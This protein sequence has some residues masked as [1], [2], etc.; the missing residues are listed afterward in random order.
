MNQISPN[1]NKKGSLSS[2]SNTDS[3]TQVNPKN[4]TKN[5][6]KKK[7][8][9]KETAQRF[10]NNTTQTETL[11]YVAKQK[12]S[13]FGDPFFRDPN[14][15][16]FDSEQSLI[17]V[18]LV[19]LRGK[20]IKC[21]GNVFL[22][23][24]I[25]HIWT[26]IETDILIWLERYLDAQGFR[27]GKPLKHFSNKKKPKKSPPLF[28]RTG[29]Q[30]KRLARNI[31]EHY[32]LFTDDNLVDK[33]KKNC[34]GLVNFKNGTYSLTTGKW[35]GPTRV[36][37]YYFCTTNYNFP[38]ESD[39]LTKEKIAVLTEFLLKF[40]GEKN[41]PHSMSFL[42]RTLAGHGVKDRKICFVYGPRSGAK[43]TTFSL[44]GKAFGDYAC[45][46]DPSF[47]MCS[48]EDV[49]INQ[50]ELLARG[51]AQLTGAIFR[52]LLLAKEI[53]HNETFESPDLNF[54]R[55][56]EICLNGHLLKPTISGGD[57]VSVRKL[58]EEM[59]GVFLSSTIMFQSNGKVD[60]VPLNARNNILY[61]PTNARW[62]DGSEY[63]LQQKKGYKN[64]YKKDVNV[65]DKLI[66]D[67]VYTVFP[68]ILGQFFPKDG[69]EY[70]EH[71]FWRNDHSDHGEHAKE[72]FFDL[73]RSKNYC[74]KKNGEFTPNSKFY[75]FFEKF[76]QLLPPRTTKES[77]L[78]VLWHDHECKASSKRCKIGSNGIIKKERGILHFFL[79]DRFLE[80]TVRDVE[81]E[82]MTYLDDRT[83]I[84]ETND[85]YT[86]ELVS[87]RATPLKNIKGTRV[88]PPSQSPSGSPVDDRKIKIMRSLKYPEDNDINIPSFS[89]RGSA[90]LKELEKSKKATE[91][92]KRSSLLTDL[93]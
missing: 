55:N 19:A 26:S 65:R 4:S 16:I 89:P 76:K 46:F 50:H 68:L 37:Q 7:A 29:N 84:E 13:L 73:L 25:K 69:V 45:D 67:E 30:L 9:P 17:T 70:P 48:R 59:T 54:S 3:N 75:A 20:I 5:T 51:M 92:S 41:F 61:F 27:F 63:E 91:N 78:N 74:M 35:L 85:G 49:R 81:E 23:D 42:S 80:K 2:K 88:R 6:S 86:D 1:N 52:R 58:Y 34:Q 72:D 87:V 53:A 33:I 64:I 43:G 93:Q 57:S 21:K 32:G 39:P 66:Y 10:F 82:L 79:D 44:I 36:N 83:N 22:R 28:I 71:L 8:S 62:I 18:V 38:D 60:T 47:M 90:R 11:E 56:K 14:N 31:F 40:W 77:F 12:L 15:R 24:D